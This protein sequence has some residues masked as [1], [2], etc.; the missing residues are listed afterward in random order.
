MSYYVVKG[1]KSLSGSIETVSGKNATIALLF[2]SLL[3]KGKTTLHDMTRVQEVHRVLELLESIGVSF[4][5]KDET[6]LELDTSKKLSLDTI[7]KKACASGR[8]SLLLMGALAKREKAFKLYRTSGCDLGKRTVNP[9]IFGMQKFG[10][11]VEKKATYYNI[12][13]TIVKGANI[14]MYESGDTTTENIIMAAVLAKG[15]TTIKFASANYMVQDLCHFLKKAGA[16]IS[17]IGTTTLH[18]SGVKKLKDTVSYSV[19]PDPIDAMAWIALAIT[20]KSPLTI[21]NCPLEFLELELEKLA[22]MGQEFN[23]KNKHSNKEGYLTVCDIQIIPS[24]LTALPDKIC[25]RPFPGL[26]IDNLPFFA[27]IATQAEGKTLIHDW[28]YENRALYNLEFQKLGANV[29]LLDPHRVIIEGPTPLKANEVIAPYAIRPAMSILIAMIA[30]KGT[31]I[32]R[33]IYPIE[34]AYDNLIERLQSIGVDI[35]K[36][37]KI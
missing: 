1:G 21:K 12:K 11:E 29:I 23:I 20:T 6:T 35:I 8:I 17:G 28:P 10:I 7:D 27:P 14:V 4:I 13:N 19:A 22:V 34:R 24:K 2:A 18:I 26:N 32:L 31:S 3:L 37:E 15:D 9:H 5:W 25:G 16:N 30:A 33:N 36:E